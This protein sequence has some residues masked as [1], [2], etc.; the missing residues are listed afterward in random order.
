MGTGEIDKFFN[1]KFGALQYRSLNFKTETLNREYVQEVAVVNY[2][3]ADTPYTRIIEHKHFLD[4][5][6]DKTIISYE[7]PVAAG[8][9]KE[10][11][12]PIND[13]TNNSLYK[14]YLTEA[15]TCTDVLFGGRLGEY[16]YYDMDKTILRA[17]E[18][19]KKEK[20]PTE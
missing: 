9:G 11:F 5:K 14:K 13:E 2:T 12:Y 20:T 1:Y 10:A 3:D 4:E 8:S 6:S 18:A 16:K 17:M 15:E 7:Y 19:W